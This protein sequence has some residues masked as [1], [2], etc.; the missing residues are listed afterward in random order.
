M[1]KYGFSLPAEETHFGSLC[2]HINHIDTE[3]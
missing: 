2:P 3:L 1:S